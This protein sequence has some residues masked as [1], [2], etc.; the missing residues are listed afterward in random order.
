MSWKM[1]GTYVESCNCETACPCVF[2]S[3]PT[4]DECTL[5]VGWHIDEGHLDGITLDGLNVSLAVQVDG[6]MMENKWNVALYLDDR[7]NDQQIDALGKIFGGQLGGVPAA[8]GEHI[9]AVVG[10]GPAPISF[11]V[12]GSDV[13]LKIGEIASM[14]VSAIEGQNGGRV[15]I[16]GQPL[17]IAPGYPGVVGRSEYL[18]YNDHGMSWELTGKNSFSSPFQYSG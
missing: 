11:E 7:A 12:D 3:P 16:V 1:S 5:L 4:E 13:S 8:L 10:A 17:A 14:K 6:H 9:G 15:E 18:T 2:L